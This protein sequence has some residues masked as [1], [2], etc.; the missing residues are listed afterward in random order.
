MMKMARSSLYTL[1]VEGAS[2]FCCM[3]YIVEVEGL[4]TV[5]YRLGIYT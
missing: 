4:H 2:T 1:V 3:S 5:A